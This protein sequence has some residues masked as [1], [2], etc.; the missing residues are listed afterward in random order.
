MLRFIQSLHILP[1][2]IILL[3]DISI[4]A[5]SFVLAYFIRFDFDLDRFARISFANGLMYYVILNLVS[6]FITQSYAGIIRHT[7][8]QDGY[9]IAHTT[10]LGIIFTLI[11]NYVYLFFEGMTMIPWG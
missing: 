2:W 7:G 3:L 11:V 5:S 9:R 8:L 10:T 1:R 4:L 6:I